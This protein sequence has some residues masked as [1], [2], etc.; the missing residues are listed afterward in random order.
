M[1]APFLIGRMLFGG[2]FLYSGM[3]HLLKHKEMAPYAGAKGVPKPDMAVTLAGV[4][5]V[6][7]GASLVLGVK[8]KLGTMAIL[9]FLLGVSPIMHNFWRSQ[10]S[11]ERMNESINFMKN[12]ALAGGALALMGVEEPWEASLAAGRPSLGKRARAVARKIAA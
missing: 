6:A 10:D 8:P 2:F 5:L 7:G 3:H 1:K 4:P 9:G 12:L 11:N